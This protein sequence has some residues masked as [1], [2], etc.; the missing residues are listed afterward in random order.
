M[1]PADR[2]PFAELLTATMEVYNANL[3]PAGIGIWWAALAPYSLAEVRG[4]LSGH[5]T[6]AG[7]GKF[8]P[9]PAD[10]IAA[11]QGA[12][13]RPTADEAWALC[14]RGEGDTVVWTEEAAQAFLEV[15]RELAQDDHI[16]ARMAF[17]GAYDRAVHMARGSRRPLHWTVSLGH[18]VG[19]RES[20]LLDAAERGRIT[21][22]Q[23][24]A[25]IPHTGE[26]SP[27]LLALLQAGTKRLTA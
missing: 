13:G 2:A 4:G 21:A 23:A 19:G 27:R 10:V 16:A 20:V 14:P 8:A 7:A 24:N 12:D 9:K 5:V 25:L 26:P 3:T 22:G 17:K 6:A 1:K 18:D 15:T 11:I